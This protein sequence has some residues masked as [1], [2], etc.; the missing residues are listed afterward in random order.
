GLQAEGAAL[1]LDPQY[2]EQRLRYLLEDSGV[3]LLLSGAAVQ[4]RL[5]LAAG[6]EVLWR[7]QAQAWAPA[8]EVPAPWPGVAAGNLAYSIY[9]SGSTGAAK[10][11]TISHGAL[12]N[13][14]QAIILRLP[15]VAA[16]TM[17][18]VSTIAAD[19]GHTTLFGSLCSGSCLHVIDLD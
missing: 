14:V 19:L 18:V 10:G 7:D 9:T 11:V 8:S 13:Y 15:L 4:P 3:R 2:P 12:A 6:V 17:A 5:P 1:P 16:R